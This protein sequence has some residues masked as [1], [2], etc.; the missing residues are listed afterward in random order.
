MFMSFVLVRLNRFFSNHFRSWRRTIPNTNQGCFRYRLA[1]LFFYHKS[2]VA[3]CP[4][5]RSWGNK[6]KRMLCYHLIMTTYSL[7][8]AAPSPSILG[9]LSKDVFEQRTST[10]S[11][12]YLSICLD[13]NK[14]VFSLIKMIFSRVWTKPLPN[15]A[16]SPL[17]VDSVAYSLLFEGSG[18]LYT[19]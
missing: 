12:A 9:S 14:F 5:S 1:V 19:G 18:R 8:T 2:S 17:P 15:D 11:E 13:T 7:F 10:G 16:K 4:H 6:V 3:I